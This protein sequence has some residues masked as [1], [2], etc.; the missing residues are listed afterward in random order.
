MIVA[1]IPPP[2]DQSAVAQT[3]HVE[4]V[5][6]IALSMRKVRIGNWGCC[7]CPPNSQLPK[8][9]LEGFE[10]PHRR[11]E[12]V[13][14]PEAEGNKQPNCPPPFRSN[15]AGASTPDRYYPFLACRCHALGGGL[16]RRTLSPYLDKVAAGVVG[17]TAPRYCL[18]GDTVSSPRRIIA[19]Q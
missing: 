13:K 6:N 17:L 2:K 10:I 7:P 14:A 11:R 16:S 15:A 9:F 19:D 8:Q 4:Q 12:R 5:S 3:K 1:G 18:F